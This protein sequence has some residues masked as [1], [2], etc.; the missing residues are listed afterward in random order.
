MGAP[1]DSLIDDGKEDS[2]PFFGISAV[3]MPT[4]RHTFQNQDF[5]KS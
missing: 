1:I 2:G 3:F 5:G 4:K